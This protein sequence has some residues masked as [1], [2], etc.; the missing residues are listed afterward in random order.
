MA[1]FRA[2]F[3]ALALSSSAASAL[4]VEHSVGADLFASMEPDFFLGADVFGGR[5]LAST[6]PDLSCF[7][8]CG[9]ELA[10]AWFDASLACVS[11]CDPQLVADVASWC[12]CDASCASCE[13]PTAA[14]CVTCGDGDAF[15]AG[16]GNDGTGECA[17]YDSL[18]GTAN[19]TA[20]DMA[21]YPDDVDDDA[22]GLGIMASAVAMAAGATVAAADVTVAS[23]QVTDTVAGA[24][25]IAYS[26]RCGADCEAVSRLFAGIAAEPS[27]FASYVVA[28]SLGTPMAAT[29]APVEGVDFGYGR[30]DSGED[31]GET[32]LAGDVEIRVDAAAAAAAD[33]AAAQAV[34]EAALATF[35]ELP[36]GVTAGAP[37]LACDGDCALAV[38]Y[39]ADFGSPDAL[40]AAAARAAGLAAAPAT[41]DV[42][43][44]AAAEA[45]GDAAVVA[46]FATATTSAT[47]TTDPAASP[48]NEPAAAADD[49]GDKADW[50]AAH[51]VLLLAV[52]CPAFALLGLGA[53]LAVARR[54]GAAASSA[55]PDKGELDMD[56]EAN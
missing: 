26:F 34:V 24:A 48:L 19:I 5:R 22:V 11:D 38:D 32:R 33:A 23:M 6:E 16:A 8:D 31:D 30:F 29:C 3:L 43:L 9:L 52:A 53:G 1:C 35:F 47:A 51:W 17:V 13:G 56:L 54:G 39:I 40:A 27:R 7:D 45:H 37:A 18:A 20:L 14:H 25:T 41:L 55:T 50:F 21:A 2:L 49:D 12:T 4:E 44:R 28:A 15:F 10:C 42:Y 36:G 46:L